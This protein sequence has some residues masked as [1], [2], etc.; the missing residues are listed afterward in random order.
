MARF[1]ACQGKK[2]PCA[3]ASNPKR[4]CWQLGGAFFSGAESCGAKAFRPGEA[5]LKLG[6]GPAFRKIRWEI[7]RLLC[8]DTTWTFNQ[9]LVLKWWTKAETSYFWLGLSLTNLHL[10]GDCSSPGLF[11]K[12]ALGGVKEGKFLEEHRAAFRGFGFRD[13]KG[14]V[15]SPY[16][17]LTSLTGETQTT[18]YD[19]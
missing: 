2:D 12:G 7:Q 11:L 14:A 5:A 6:R 17:H 9:N 19:S 1:S 8:P 13:F 10:P 18:K 4:F 3:L 16:S 15:G